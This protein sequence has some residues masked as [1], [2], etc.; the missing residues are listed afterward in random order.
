MKKNRITSAL[1]ALALIS[2]AA[3]MQ[4][5]QDPT[6]KKRS[7]E[8]RFNKS[9]ARFRRCMKGNCTRME[10]VKAA[11]DVGIAAILF[12]T[13]AVAGDLAKEAA[14]IKSTGKPPEHPRWV[15]PTLAPARQIG[16]FGARAYKKM[17][18][19]AKRF[20]DPFG[21]EETLSK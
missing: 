5:A 15:T 21:L 17:Q 12:L 10:M 19:R 9:L 8:E 16:R 13:V 2:A 7:L 3:P 14:I 11:R 20:G 18:V 1:L 4:A 6:A